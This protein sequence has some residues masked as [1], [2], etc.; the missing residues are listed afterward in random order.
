MVD[1]DHEQHEAAEEIEFGIAAGPG[2]RGH[3]ASSRPA[4]ALARARRQRAARGSG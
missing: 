2:G 3:R 1:D 4:R